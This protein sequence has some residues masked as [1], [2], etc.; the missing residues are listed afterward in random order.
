MKKLI[1]NTILFAISI[2]AFAQK[3][4]DIQP[5]N[6]ETDCNTN[7]KTIDVLMALGKPILIEHGMTD[8]GNCREAA[9]EVSAFAE[10]NKDKATF[11]LGV[12]KMMGEATCKNITSWQTEFAGYKNF[13]AFLDNDKTYQYG[14]GL[15]PTL[16]VVNPTTKKIM[17]IGNDFQ[18]ASKML[19][20]M[21]PTAVESAARVLQ[22]FSL[23]P[24]PASGLVAVNFDMVGESSAII[25]ITNAL[26][27]QVASYSIGGNAHVSK[28]IDISNLESGVYALTVRANEAVLK[29]T[30]LIVE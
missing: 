10:L 3:V 7:T 22:N 30:K 11:I 28:N 16:T 8:C 5:N 21:M 24:N 26:G 27:M 6:S 4:G 23:Y 19:E 13:F 17:Y 20:S 15:M 18:I 14:T 9:P 1:L 12:S 29:N 25:Q 2:N